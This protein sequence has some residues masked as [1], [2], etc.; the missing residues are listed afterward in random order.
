M[1]LVG[2]YRFDDGVVEALKR[3][4][5]TLNGIVESFLGKLTCLHGVR[6]LLHLLKSS[7]QLILK[8]WQLVLL[9]VLVGACL[10][11]SLLGCRDPPVSLSTSPSNALTFSGRPRSV[12]SKALNACWT[13]CAQLSSPRL[14]LKRLLFG[15]SFQFSCGSLDQS[16]TPRKAPAPAVAKG[17]YTERELCHSI[18]PLQ[19][20]TISTLCWSA[21][22]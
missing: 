13:F 4:S 12:S 7:L 21:F 18:E 10:C 6:Y 17:R 9:L 19:P 3:D 15:L 1:R 14:L 8:P 20:N 22:Y 16:P 11:E 2:L 5:L